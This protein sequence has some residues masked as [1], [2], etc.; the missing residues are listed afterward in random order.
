ML[1]LPD[2]TK[3][4]IIFRGFGKVTRT[5]RGLGHPR[6][7]SRRFRPF[8]LSLL[9]L[10]C[11]SAGCGVQ[12]PKAPGG[13]VEQK[14]T[15]ATLGDPKTFNLIVSNETSSTAVVGILF[16][17]LTQRNPKTTEIEPLLAESWEISPDGRVWTFH[18]RKDVRWNDGTPFTA[19]DVKFTFDAIYHP[20][21]PNTLKDVLTLE[22]QRVRVEVLDAHTVRFTL[23][24]PFAPFLDIL[25]LGILP[26]HKLEASLKAGT[27]ASAW[28]INTPPREIVGTGPYRLVEYVP[29]QYV[30][31]ERNPF[32]WK[33]DEAGRPLPYIEERTLLIVK[34][35][36]T[37]FVK[38]VAGE[39]DIH[40]PRP[41][42]VGTLEL[43][44]R[45]LDITVKELGLA[46]GT[47]FIVFNRNPKHYI[48]DGKRDP[49]L[50]WFTDLNFLRALAHSID[51]DTIISNTLRGLGRPAVAEISP[52][53]KRFHNPDL[54]DYEYDLEK[55]K[56]YLER[57]GYRDRDGDG[58]REDPNGNPIVFDLYTN[59]GNK[60]REQMCAII[61]EDWTRLGLKVNYRP[62]E[63]NTLVEKL[64][65]NYQWDAILIGLTGGLEPH[66][67]ASFYKSSG[68]LHMW[69]PNQE[70]PATPWEAEIDRLVDQGAR[71]LDP[72]KR[73][74][75]YKRIQAIL[76]EQLPILM[77]VR[78][79]VF[80][81]YRNRIE[82]YE[83]TIWGT[84]RP[85]R[86]RI[87]Y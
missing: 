64:D 47:P 33:K 20:D 48:R 86:M 87:A 83:P 37:G 81:A 43:R 78:Q 14:L 73:A 36:N 44:A 28:N 2:D 38:F 79:S 8:A 45:E 59:A 16:E 65:S 32:Y 24:F 17:G 72:E 18:L 85:E 69:H 76:H 82:N 22:G 5:P 6:S 25:G 62:L 57:G 41:E 75:I 68:R 39:T 10:A 19:H 11:L 70:T 60:I 63:F 26:R 4:N 29:S 58:I 23:P 7:V 31:Y 21:V 67:G 15:T 77:T 30:R 66:W 51:K 71:E 27:F 54:K 1:S 46:T 55:A 61:L 35:L 52:E 49:K 74:A 56:A 84:Y 40:N 80:V 13:A 12:P 34:D 3:I 53:V 42:D 50:D 9:A